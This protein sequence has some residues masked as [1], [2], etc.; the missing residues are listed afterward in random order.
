MKKS[1]HI[2]DSEGKRVERVEELTRVL[3][4]NGQALVPLLELVAD[5]R[6][7]VDEIIDVA[8]RAAIQAVLELSAQEATGEALRQPG[9]KRAGDIVRWGRQAGRVSLSDRKLRVAKP[10]LRSRAG[11]EV[12]VAV[13]VLVAIVRKRL[14]LET[15]LYQILQILSVTLFEKT[16]ISQA[17]QP[18][19]SQDLLLVDPNQLILFD[20]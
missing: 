7:A 15:S 4:R 8:G 14:G 20:L 13:Y 16:P 19:D 2:E 9:K 18:S 12:A 11:E 6:G 3:S 17:L 1:Y 5:C 10:R